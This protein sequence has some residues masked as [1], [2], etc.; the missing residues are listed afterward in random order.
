MKLSNLANVIDVEHDHGRLIEIGL[1]IVNLGER[2]I[3]KTH[4]LPIKI[5][6]EL[7][8]V[9]SDLTGWTTTKLRR[10]GM[11]LAEVNRLLFGYGCTNRL[12]IAD[13]SDEISVLEK[14][15]ST[16]LSPHRINVSILFS[17]A[18]GKDIN[19]G[20]EAMLAEFGMQFEGTPHSGADDSMNIA[21]LFLR[22]LQVNLTEAD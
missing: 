4:R 21:R 5:D 17:L 10:Q 16:E 9:I 12:L 14:M 1:T 13:S 19:L 2:Q 6:F 3:L 20:L 15:L 18:T 7:S 8:P 11:A 22:L